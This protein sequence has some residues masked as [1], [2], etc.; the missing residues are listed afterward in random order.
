MPQAARDAYFSEL[1]GWR[2]LAVNFV[3][4]TEN[5][6]SFD[7]AEPWAR[8][9]LLEHARDRRLSHC[10]SSCPA[11]RDSGHGFSGLGAT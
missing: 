5:C 4:F 9:T 10:L 8:K 3:K 2:E 1:I 6:D 11:G 7:C